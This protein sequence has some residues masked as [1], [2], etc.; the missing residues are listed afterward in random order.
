MKIKRIEDEQVYL[1]MNDREV[2]HS[3]TQV[4]PYI[5]L[6]TMEYL[7]KMR[8]DYTLKKVEL[9]NVFKTAVLPTIDLRKNSKDFL[10]VKN[11]TEGLIK[12]IHGLS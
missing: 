3:I 6:D 5:S 9:N 10:N 4:K 8:F 2:Q 1:D 7:H 12:M 11:A